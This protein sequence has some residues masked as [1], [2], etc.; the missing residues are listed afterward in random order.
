MTIWDSMRRAL[1]FSKRSWEA[2]PGFKAKDA[3]WEGDN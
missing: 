3:Q 1:G 2:K